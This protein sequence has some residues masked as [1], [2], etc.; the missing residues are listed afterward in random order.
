MQPGHLNPA[1]A[2]DCPVHTFIRIHSL[3]AVMDTPLLRIA[4]EMARKEKIAKKKKKS[5]FTLVKEKRLVY[6]SG[7]H[8]DDK[9]VTEEKGE[10]QKKL[11]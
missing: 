5:P 7:W 10:K 8:K 1:R 11:V 4:K 3:R 9:P 2:L 6:Y